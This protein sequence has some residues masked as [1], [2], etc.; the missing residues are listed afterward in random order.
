MEV[1]ISLILFV[2]QILV[3]GTEDHNHYLGIYKMPLKSQADLQNTSLFTSA[4]TNQRC[5]PKGSLW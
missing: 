3:Y 1:V 2:I 5:F 4:A